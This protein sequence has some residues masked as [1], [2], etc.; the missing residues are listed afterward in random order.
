MEK[1]NEEAVVFRCQEC[2]GNWVVEAIDWDADGSVCATV[3]AGPDAERRAEEYAQAKYRE[4]RRHVQDR[5]PYL[6][7]RGDVGDRSGSAP[8]H[9]AML[10]LVK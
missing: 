6:V 4:F 7:Y 2:P 8:S 3:F 10:H 5:R 1:I 9:G